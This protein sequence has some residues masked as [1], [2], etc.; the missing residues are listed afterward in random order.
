MLNVTAYLL[1]IIAKT[2]NSITHT[3]VVDKIMSDY[4]RC[5]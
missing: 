1:V 3:F 4:R 2:S 5:C